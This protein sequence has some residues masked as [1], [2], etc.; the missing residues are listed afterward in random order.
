MKHKF[1]LTVVAIL[2]GSAPCF[3][4]TNIAENDNPT[5]KTYLNRFLGIACDKTATA[6]VAVGFGKEPLEFQRLVYTTQDAGVTWSAPIALLSVPAETK[7]SIHHAKISCDATGQKCI[8]VSSAMKKNIPAPIVYSTKDGG[9]TWSDPMLLPLPKATVEQQDA[10]IG[11]SVSC[12]DSGDNC[13]IAGALYN[14]D[15]SNNHPQRDPLLYTTK[16]AGHTWNLSTLPAATTYSHGTTL[17]NV[18]CDNSGLACVIVGNALTKDSFWSNTYSSK[19]IVYTTQDGGTKWSKPIILPTAVTDSNGSTLDDVAC[20]STGSQCTA[21]GHT[22]D[23]NATITKYFS[24]ATA[25]SGVAWGAQSEVFS[26]DSINGELRSLD[27][28]EAANHCTAV[29]TRK[30]GNIKTKMVYKPLIYSTT[31]GA[32]NWVRNATLSFPTFSYLTD[33]ACSKTENRCIAVGIQDDFSHVDNTLRRVQKKHSFV[34][35]L[36]VKL[37]R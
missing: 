28:D 27:C 17:V 10:E 5:L 12:N 24:F 18:N 29:G 37:V 21:I 30:F 23:H 13:V 16:D 25:N 22:E 2:M 31:N 36:Q 15:D 4:S 32:A 6:C 35:S 19:P 7:D 34:P 11:T 9:L 1:K 3:A 20:N 33:I 26:S 14:D 8:I